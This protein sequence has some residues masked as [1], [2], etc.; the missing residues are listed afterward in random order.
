MWKI[1]REMKNKTENS[2]AQNW[3]PNNKSASKPSKKL[4]K[5]KKCHEEMFKPIECNLILF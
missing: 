3:S 4:K 1:T 2:S 5:R